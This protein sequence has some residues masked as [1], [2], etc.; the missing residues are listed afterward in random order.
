MNIFN[1]MIYFIVLCF[2]MIIPLA[3]GVYTVII[4]LIHNRGSKRKK[5]ISK[6]EW[7]RYT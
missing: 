4:I 3:V 5:D 1:S 6:E 2:L 7:K